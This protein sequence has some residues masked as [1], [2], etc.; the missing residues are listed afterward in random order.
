MRKTLIFACCLFSYSSFA[1][2]EAGLAY[3]LSVPLKEMGNNIQVTHSAVSDVRYRFKKVQNKFW[4][5]IQLS[6]GN[7]ASKTEKQHYEFRDGSITEADVTFTSNIF[8]AHLTGGYDFLKDKAVIP[9]ITAKLGISNF[10]SMVF[11]GDPNDNNGCKPLKQKNVFNDAALSA[12]GGI[13]IKINADKVFK[14]TNRTWWINFSVNYLTGGN[15]SY[16]NVKHLHHD[17]MMD[18][19]SKPFLVQFVNIST[20]EIHEHSVAEVFKSRINM[21][22]IKVGAMFPLRSGK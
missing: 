13:G 15:L 12:G 1:Q 14:A 7:Y 9:Y 4:A 21:V 10:Y 17:S 22:D 2:F 6:F 20:N 11:I 16:L 19:D 18:P 5:G 8:S 3:S